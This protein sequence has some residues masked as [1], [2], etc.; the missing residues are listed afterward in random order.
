MIPKRPPL[1]SVV[2]EAI[3]RFIE[4]QCGIRLGPE[5][6]YLVEHRLV[7]VLQHFQLTSFEALRDRL[8][9]KQDH[10]MRDRVLEAIT[11]HETA[12]FRDRHPFEA[13]R[14]RMRSKNPWVRNGS[15]MFTLR[16][17]TMLRSSGRTSWRALAP[18]G[19]VRNRAT[20]PG[21]RP[22]AISVSV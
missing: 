17:S 12:F 3:S 9:D 18:T 1:T 16:N 19:R 11:T 7:P 6:G 21:V 10:E 15:C 8:M 5:K 20:W 13:L 4:Q 2:Q 14:Q 22:R